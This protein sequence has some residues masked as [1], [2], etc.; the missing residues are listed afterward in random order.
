VDGDGVLELAFGDTGGRL[1]VVNPDG[2][3]EWFWDNPT[4]SGIYGPPQAMDIDGD[5]LVEFFV[6]DNNGF[7]YRLN[8]L[9]EKVWESRQYDHSMSQ[10]TICD[11]DRD[12]LYEVVFSEYHG[13]V[14]CLDAMLGSLKWIYSAEIDGSIN[15]FVA[16]M[17]VNK[18]GFNEIIAW[19]EGLTENTGG[20]YCI[21]YYGTSIWHWPT[22]V[23]GHARVCQA[24]GD[25][26]EDGSM[27]IILTTTYGIYC[28]DI[29]GVAPVLRW[30]INV[31]EMYD[32]GVL[33]APAEPSH[34]GNYQ[35]IVDFDGDDK[36]EVLLQVPYPIVLDAETGEIEA[37]Y[38]NPD[39]ASGRRPENGGAWGDVDNDGKS[40]WVMD[41]NGV[42]H[43]KSQIYCF[44]MGG[45]YPAKA[46][47]AEYS[48]SAYPAQYQAE[49]EWLLLKGVSSNSLWF[50]VHE[51]LSTNIAVLLTIGLLKTQHGV[52]TSLD[53][54]GGDW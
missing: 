46:F 51:F 32:Q 35:L 16:V 50:P 25:V 39:I 29:G 52:I 11:L 20:V 26:D 49:Q 33:P 43:E 8:H 24:L 44:T 15:P 42:S 36:L 19:G 14:I 12:G 41:L 21:S 37:C 54:L 45:K 18:D 9:G 38:Y 22:P 47:W 48:H 6:N 23:Q 5:G 53:P 13:R 34:W 10:P 1:H 40:E 2:S 31:T 27:E 4:E 7:V 3:L 17:D 30:E 28:V